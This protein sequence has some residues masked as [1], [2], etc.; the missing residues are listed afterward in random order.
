MN[1]IENENKVIMNRNNEIT[2]IMGNDIKTIVY[3]HGFG[4]SGQSGTVK[5]LRKVLPQFNVLAPDIPICPSEALPFLK[6]YCK[7]YHPDLII[8]TSMGGMYAMQ[9]HD[10]KRMCVNPAL[11]MSE[12]TDI[13]KPGTFKYFQPSHNG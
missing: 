1:T 13:L 9:M 8:G 7:K 6:D 11:R 2:E 3:L 5:H 4:S 12:L 10:Y